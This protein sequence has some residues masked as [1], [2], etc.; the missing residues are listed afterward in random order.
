[1]YRHLLV[2]SALAHPV[3][4]QPARAEVPVSVTE[5]EAYATG[6]TLSYAQ[7]GDIF[8]A[9]QYLPGRRVIW[10]FKGQQCRAGSW[11]EDAGQVCFVYEDAPVPQCW[12]FHRDAGGLRARF[13]GDVPGAAP[14][15]VQESVPLTCSGPDLGV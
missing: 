11:Y 15:T 9:E 6:K 5:F 3:L 14:A 12:T 2:L 8:G 13:S 10:A 1:M 7:D 4:A